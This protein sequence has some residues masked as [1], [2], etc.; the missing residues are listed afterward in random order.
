MSEIDKAYEAFERQILREFFC[1]VDHL[2]E[3]VGQL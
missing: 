2:G 3:A 1:Q